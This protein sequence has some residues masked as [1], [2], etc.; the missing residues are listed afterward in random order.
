MR[1]Q[2]PDLKGMSII[3][4][5]LTQ[6]VRDHHC[7]VAQAPPRRFFWKTLSIDFSS[8]AFDYAWL[9]A[10][11]YRRIDHGAPGFVFAQQFALAK[12]S[13]AVLSQPQT[14]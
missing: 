2:Q 6:A 12:A 11:S 8:R 9:G 3:L 1:P 5:P 10:R 13:I 4:M 7:A 14:N